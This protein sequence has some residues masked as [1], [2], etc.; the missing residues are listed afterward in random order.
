MYTIEPLKINYTPIVY[1]TVK[2][3]TMPYVC[4][5]YAVAVVI[6]A[7]A[8]RH[9]MVCQLMSM[10]QKS[11]K[12]AYDE[13]KATNKLKKHFSSFGF[14]FRVFFL[15]LCSISFELSRIE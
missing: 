12:P 15:L 11:K 10:T 7:T 4:A 13:P 1:E 3:L 14:F 8:A 2:D 9:A 6:T 5:F